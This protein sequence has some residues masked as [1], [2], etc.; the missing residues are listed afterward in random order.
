LVGDQQPIWLKNGPIRC[1]GKRRNLESSTYDIFRYPL[2]LAGCN[3]GVS[4]RS[5]G[6]DV[7]RRRLAADRQ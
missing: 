2:G 4:A 3:D 1:A 5:L 6:R 7:D